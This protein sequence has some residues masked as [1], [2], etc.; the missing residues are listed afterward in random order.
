MKFK[1]ILI[2]ILISLYSCTIKINQ[3]FNYKKHLAPEQVAS[4][5]KDLKRILEKE[6]YDI[7]W[8]GKKFSIFSSLDSISKINEPISIDS[9]EKK[10]SS[11]INI[12]DDGHSKVIHQ[13]STRRLKR[14]QFGFQSI[15]DSVA[16]LRIGNFINT[17]SLIRTLENFRLS[18]NKDPKEILILDIRSNRG[19]SS[20]NVHRTLTY[21]LPTKTK[22]YE[23]ID[24]RPT[25]AI[26]WIPRKIISA[27]EN[28]KLFKYTGK[29][30]VDQNFK[31]FLW[32]NDS[33]ASGS[34]LLS[35]HLKKNGALVIGEVPKGIFSTFGN[36]YG[37]QLKNSK[38][39]YTLASARVYVT[40]KKVERMED[41]LIPDYIPYSTWDLPDIVNYIN[42]N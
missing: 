34:M 15:S 42:R 7:N 5:I 14:N 40:E 30:K 31:I 19:G 37:Y 38:I 3:N 13:D 1:I 4:D 17:E 23:K 22:L 28:L 27:K 21:F 2:F 39:I 16:Y 26:N 41:M 29:K 24:F 12:I 33:I 10:L 8:D 11:I 25:S 36:S 18:F 35:Y 6:H 32:I 9:F 20:R